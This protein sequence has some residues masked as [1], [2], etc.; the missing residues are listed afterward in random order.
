ML[1]VVYTDLGYG[2]DNLN[3]VVDKCTS[4]EE[5]QVKMFESGRRG[6]LSAQRAVK[7]FCKSGGI[8]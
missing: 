4:K 6:I 7:M 3:C 8:R 5:K 2:D 1:K